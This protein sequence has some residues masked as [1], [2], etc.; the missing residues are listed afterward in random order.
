MFER[1]DQS[2]CLFKLRS[3]YRKAVGNCEA[4]LLYPFNNFLSLGNLSCLLVVFCKV[5]RR[6]KDPVGKGLR[7][8]SALFNLL[9]QERNGPVPLLK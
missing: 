8:L 5:N 3:H 7:C 6:I 4:L 1:A 2:F 9:T